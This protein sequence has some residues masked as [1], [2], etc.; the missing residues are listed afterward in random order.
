[1][2]S[3]PLVHI[4]GLSNMRRDNGEE[5]EKGGTQEL[6]AV[7]QEEAREALTQDGHIIPRRVDKDTGGGARKVEEAIT[8]KEILNALNNN[9][10]YVNKVYVLIF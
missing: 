8:I 6:E 9:Q 3:I 5:E 2:Q 4:R 7:E 1:M 10:R